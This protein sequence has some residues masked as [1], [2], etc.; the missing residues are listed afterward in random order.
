MN[1][2]EM[3]DE[4]S[5]DMDVSENGRLLDSNGNLKALQSKKKLPFE[6]SI[7]TFQNIS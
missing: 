3:D 5:S 7:K 6:H 4:D 1:V 2:P